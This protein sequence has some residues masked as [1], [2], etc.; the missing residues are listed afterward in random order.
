MKKVNE[1]KAVKAEKKVSKSETRRSAV[2][3]KPTAK[4]AKPVK[5]TISEDEAAFN[6]FIDGFDP[7]IT[8]RCGRLKLFAIYQAG[9]KRGKSSKK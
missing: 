3:K 2:Q 1:K 7:S 8:K 4:A 5:K 9:I 6:K